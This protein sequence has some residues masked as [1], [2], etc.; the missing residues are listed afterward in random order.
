VRVQ[1]QEA[2][3]GELGAALKRIQYVEWTG[4]QD[5]GRLVE[6][7]LDVI[8]HP[9]PL[10]VDTANIRPTGGVVPL[11]S[12]YYIVRP[13]DEQFLDAIRRRDSIVLVKGARQMGKTSLLARGLD[14]ARKNGIKAIATDFQQLNSS[15]LSS[16]DKFY[17]AM[18]NLIAEELGLD[19]SRETTWKA[20]YSPNENFA[21]FMTREVLAKING[22]FVWGMDEVDRMFTCD[23]ATDVFALFRSWFNKRSLN[24]DGPWKNLTMAIVYATEAY[25]FIK[26]INQSPFN[27]G[28]KLELA[29]FN[30]EQVEQ[31]NRLYGSPLRG[32]EETSRFYRIVGGSPY[33]VHRGL[34]VLQTDRMSLDEFEKKADLDEG[35]FGDH[36]RR[37]V[38][39]LAKNPTLQDAVRQVL[40]GKTSIS[41]DDFVRLRSAG[42]LSGESSDRVSPRS[43]LYEE[44]LKLNLA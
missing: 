26:D 38:V 17:P 35:P 28:T 25:L 32:A 40:S 3:P 36:L 34:Q 27:V 29:D 21:R 43:Q 19:F 31:L 12:K 13:T 16:I 5:N 8:D 20:D 15:D 33:L 41:K 4:E 23:F 39:M 42:V 24:P 44:F 2:V 22:P 9:P 1:F 7:L 6:K 14:L 30:L 11:D 37:I 18:A 10:E